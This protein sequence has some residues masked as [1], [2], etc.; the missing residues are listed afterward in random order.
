MR[1]WKKRNPLVVSGRGGGTMMTFLLNSAIPVEN[2]RHFVRAAHRE[3]SVFAG[4]SRLVTC[5]VAPEVRNFYDQYHLWWAV[6][7]KLR[8]RNSACFQAGCDNGSIRLPRSASV[9]R[10]ILSSPSPQF[11]IFFI[12]LF[13]YSIILLF[14]IFFQFLIY[15]IL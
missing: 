10:N 2:H 6:E 14:L 9:G 12:L 8:G 11:L 7:W 15:I 5:T 3:R 4:A 13:L 1:V